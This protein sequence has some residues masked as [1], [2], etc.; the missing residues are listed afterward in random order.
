MRWNVF[1]LFPK[2]RPF[3][4]RP[5]LSPIGL[6]VLVQVAA[7]RPPS[8]SASPPLG[9][10]VLLFTVS[11]PSDLS[12]LTIRE[13]TALCTSASSNWICCRNSGLE[14]FIFAP[15]RL[16][17]VCVRACART[18][19]VEAHPFLRDW[20]ILFHLAVFSAS[21]Q[22]AASLH[23]G[24]SLTI[25]SLSL[26]CSCE[27]LR[28]GCWRSFSFLSFESWTFLSGLSQQLKQYHCCRN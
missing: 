21:L 14:N 9:S 2:S 17:C 6:I 15:P 18:R 23:F 10:H 26:L 8:P 4:T 1:F 5:H 13:V 11:C 22:T 20:S 16:L 27:W 12:N 7:H 24:T 19:A 28:R 25:F 3:V